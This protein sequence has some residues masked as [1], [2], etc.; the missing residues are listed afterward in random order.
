LTFASLTDEADD[1]GMVLL[2]VDMGETPRCLSSPKVVTVAAVGRR[3]KNSF[4]RTTA[5][6][7]RVHAHGL[8]CA[9]FIPS[10]SKHINRPILI[11][12]NWLVVHGRYL[13]GCSPTQH[14]V[15][16]SRPYSSAHDDDDDDDA[17]STL[18]W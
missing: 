8:S 14:G 6:P 9:G 1:D 2:A 17:G 5:T 12:K 16:L 18:L 15:A 3:T 7:R 4:C 13:S 11:D 10:S